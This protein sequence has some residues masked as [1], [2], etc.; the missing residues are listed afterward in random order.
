[1]MGMIVY[2]NQGRIYIW[3]CEYA[4]NYFHNEEKTVVAISY[5]FEQLNPNSYIVISYVC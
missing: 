2:V 5:P 4:D 1:M 3:T